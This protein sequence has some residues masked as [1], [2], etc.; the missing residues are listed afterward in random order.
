M[1]SIRTFIAVF[2][3]VARFLAD[4]FGRTRIAR[5]EDQVLNESLRASRATESLEQLQADLHG[6]G[7]ADALERWRLEQQFAGLP[8]ADPDVT[9]DDLKDERCCSNCK[10]RFVGKSEYCPDCEAHFDE[11]DL[12]AHRRARSVDAP[13]DN[14]TRD[15]MGPGQLA[16]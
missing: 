9:W 12:R 1:I 4:P 11:V 3:A 13:D 16:G 14:W 15:H 2:A 7:L 10:N 5:L 6:A 8:D